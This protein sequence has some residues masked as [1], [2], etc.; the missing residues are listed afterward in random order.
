M[1]NTTKKQVWYGELK[2]AR[3]D[4]I[5][6]HDNQLPEAQPG[7][8][9]FYHAGRGAII[10]FVKDIV[11]VNLHEL[12]DAAVA[13]AEA[14]YGAAW[15]AARAEFMAKHRARLD[16]ES[17]SAAPVRKPKQEELEPEPELE[18]ISDDF[19]DDWGDDYDD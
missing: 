10:E 3:G 18:S 13:A 16:L 1:Y 14:E 15:K 11:N 2:T 12:D 8:V 17:P 4:T 6:I 5:V 7:R 9:Y 19:D